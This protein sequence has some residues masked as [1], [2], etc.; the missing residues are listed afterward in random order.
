MSKR[1]PLEMPLRSKALHLLSSGN[2]N[3][4][5][6]AFVDLLPPELLER[7]VVSAESNYVAQLILSRCIKNTQFHFVSEGAISESQKQYDY[8]RLTCY[9]ALTDWYP[10]F[11]YLSSNTIELIVA[12]VHRDINSSTNDFSTSAVK[13]KFIFHHWD[14]DRG[15]NHAEYMD[16]YRYL[17]EN[18]VEIDRRLHLLA[19]EKS[20]DID[21]IRMILEVPLA[22]SQGIL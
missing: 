18:M 1:P 20:K 13:A 6:T 14:V 3:T 12:A 8:D 10:N 9:C 21:E 2:L 22:L 17:I 19:G 11:D 4:E 7:I 16:I 15:V 5:L